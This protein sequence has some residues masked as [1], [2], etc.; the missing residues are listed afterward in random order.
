VRLSPVA[1]S[2]PFSAAVRSADASFD[3]VTVAVSVDYLCKPKE[4]FA[5]IARVLRPGGTAY[6]SFSNRCFP[7]KVVGMWVSH[8]ATLSTFISSLVS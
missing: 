3:A 7:T 6:M 2:L 4:V 1:P 5:E 8:C